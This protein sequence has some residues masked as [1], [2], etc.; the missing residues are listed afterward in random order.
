MSYSDQ[1]QLFSL[2]ATV[3][4]GVHGNAIGHFLWSQPGTLVIEVFQYDWHSD[5]QEL[6]LKEMAKAKPP[7]TTDIEYAKIECNDKSCSEGMSGLSANVQVNITAL[8][9]IIE[10]HL[11]RRRS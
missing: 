2:Q 8:N 5:W 11:S 7:Y 4:V 6:V 3:I 9:S 10:S 1:I